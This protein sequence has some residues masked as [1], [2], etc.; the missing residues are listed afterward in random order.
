MKLRLLLVVLILVLACGCSYA[1]SDIPT[2]PDSPPAGVEFVPDSGFTDHYVL[3]LWQLVADP[4]SDSIEIAE[5]R[6]GSVHINLLPVLEPPV[7]EKLCV[8]DISFDGLI[9]DF[10]LNLTHPFPGESQFT[11]FDCCGIIF[12]KGTVTGFHDS[13]LR[14]AG[15]GETRVLNPDGYTR[16]WNPPGFSIPG[17]PVL[18]YHDGLMGL[19]HETAEFDCTLNAYKL[20][21]NDL[22]ADDD[23]LDLDPT[24]RNPFLHSVV[25]T[26]HYTIDF[27][28]GLVLNYAVDVNWEM[29]IGQVPY[30]LDDFPMEANRAEA[31]AYTVTELENSLWNPYPDGD[32]S[33]GDLSLAIE[34]WD[35]QNADLNTVWV[36][37]PGNFTFTSTSTPISGGPGYSTYQVD[38]NGATPDFGSIDILIGVESEVA[39]YWDVLPDKPLTAYFTYTA[40]V[41]TEMPGMEVLT[42]NGGEEWGIGTTEFITWIAPAFIAGMDILYSKDDFDSDINIIES[43]YPNSGLYEWLIPDDP[44]D[45]VK[46]KVME[47]GG[48]IEDVSD[49]YF[50]II[51][52]EE[53]CEF[54]PDGFTFENNFQMTGAWVHRGILTSR[55]DPVQRLFLV[56]GGEYD[57]INVYNASDPT[58]GTIASYD[59]GDMIYSNNDVGMWID[60]YSEPGVDRIIY[61]NFDH[62]SPTPGYQLKIIDWNGSGFENPQTLPKTGSIWNICVTPEGDIIHHDAV[63]IAPRFYIRDKQNGYSPTQLFTIDQTEVLINSVS[64]IKGIR[65]NPVMD[66]IILFVINADVSTGGQ[67]YALDFSG[68]IL[69]QD[70]DLFD[71]IPP[72]LDYHAGINIDLE[73]PE[74]RIICYG[75]CDDVEMGYFVRLSADFDE[76]FINQVPGMEYGPARGELGAVGF[77]SADIVLWTVPISGTGRIY[78]WSPPPDW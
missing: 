5:L 77:P 65:Y 59:T 35:H 23:V 43:G 67:L 49:D 32:T 40:T 61:N 63:S 7:N 46:V 31:W 14:M 56:S 11:G 15:D 41:A 18:R 57:H 38:I 75:G 13:D 25:L 12:T 8:T 48:G 53:Q 1:H 73:S 76:K 22:G 47:S 2:I 10:N 16:W 33:G 50:S 26:R 44:S 21:S 28:G 17:P 55:N 37:S 52:L 64:E 3:G 62:G 36:D 71:S 69:Y 51:E 20:F 27:A 6:T 70:M 9:C 42:P 74:C 78:E 34:I 58:S 39:G 4:D 68:N 19:P 66:A 54:G 30:D 29:P 24:N 60:H 72:N 45:A